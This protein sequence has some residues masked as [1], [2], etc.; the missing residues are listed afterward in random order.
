MSNQATVANVIGFTS[1]LEAFLRS[2]YVPKPASFAPPTSPFQFGF[3]QGPEFVRIFHLIRLGLSSLTFFNIAPIVETV[4]PFHL[5]LIAMA[6][7]PCQNF[8]SR[9]ALRDVGLMLLG[10]WRTSEIVHP[11]N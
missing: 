7:V 3:E 8:S 2:F 9:I 6:R 11:I 10:A 1:I 5:K 4:N